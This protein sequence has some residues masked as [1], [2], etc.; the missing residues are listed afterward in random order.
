MEKERTKSKRED[1]VVMR[2]RVGAY[3]RDSF[4]PAL[5]PDFLLEPSS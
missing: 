3:E 1:L 2:R 4:P 5:F